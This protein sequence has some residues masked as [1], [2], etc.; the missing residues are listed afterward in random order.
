MDCAAFCV[1]LGLG[2]VI[3]LLVYLAS[4]N[5]VTLGLG[6]ATPLL[7][8][9]A[10]RLA[11][12]WPG[13]IVI[14]T[15]LLLVY[16][17]WLVSQSDFPK[18][19][20]VSIG[21]LRDGLDLDGIKTWLAGIDASLAAGSYAAVD[22]VVSRGF[23]VG[24]VVGFA[25]ALG[26]VV[27]VIRDPLPPRYRPF[28]L[29]CAM[30]F[31]FLC[32][33]IMLVVGFLLTWSC[34][35]TDLCTLALGGLMNLLNLNDKDVKLIGSASGIGLLFAF[36]G[37]LSASGIGLLYVLVELVVGAAG[38][39]PAAAAVPGVGKA[40]CLICNVGGSRSYAAIPC[41][42]KVWCE[43]CFDDGVWRWS[44]RCV[45]PAVECPAL[46]CSVCAVECP[47]CQAAVERV[48]KIYD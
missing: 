39:P 27:D 44:V 9:L 4:I 48:V 36:I 29:L 2:L 37:L 5:Y 6:L 43:E 31:V 16:F 7:V 33:M 1:T 45:C 23:V 47:V 21:R 19:L 28:V 40:A 14:R 12:T 15:I 20:R 11:S 13:Q 3:L 46:E 34:H 22:F 10:P 24:V 30:T 25:L 26:L 18:L 8:Y 35:Q 42:H 32:A 41:G 38:A 17:P